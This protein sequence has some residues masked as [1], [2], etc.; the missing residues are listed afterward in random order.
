MNFVIV[1]RLKL[2][3]LVFQDFFKTLCCYTINSVPKQRNGQ[4]S[5]DISE[6][7]RASTCTTVLL[8]QHMPDYKN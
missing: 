6:T 5:V 4:G 8:S 3:E 7:R 2:K 1:G